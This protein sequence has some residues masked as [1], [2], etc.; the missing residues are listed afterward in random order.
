MTFERDLDEQRRRLLELAETYPAVP[1]ERPTERP[2][3]WHYVIETLIGSFD[4]Q[5]VIRW[6]SQWPDLPTARREAER[7]RDGMVAT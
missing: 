7:L 3:D 1:A 2:D 6:L 5:D 4:Y